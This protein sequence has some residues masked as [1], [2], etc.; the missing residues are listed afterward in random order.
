MLRVVG[1]IAQR[2]YAE[3]V[4]TKGFW[5]GVLL[6]PL[7]FIAIF[8]FSSL[9]ASATPTRHFILI[10]Q[11]GNYQPGITAAIQREHQRRVLQEFAAY[12]QR[13][14]LDIN[15]EDAPA[16]LNPNEQI[17]RLLDNISNDELA[18]LDQWL[19]NGGL[20]VALAMASPSLDPDAPAFTP[21]R[22][23]FIA[24]AL[25]SG[26][27]DRASPD[28]IVSQ[29]RPWLDGQQTLNEGEEQIK[30]FALILIPANADTDIQSPDDTTAATAAID[31]S[32]GIQYWSS[33]LTDTRLST[34]IQN[35]INSTVRS[36]AYTDQ[37]IDVEAVRQIQRTRLPLTR[38]DPLK[39]EGNESVSLADTFRQ[40]APV[41]FVYLMFITLMQSV[42]YLLSNTIEEKSNRIIEVLLAS[43]T[44]GE[45]MMGKL[46]GIGMSGITTIV[47]WLV[48][49]LLF[50][51]FYQS[52]ETAVISQLL[53]VLLGS[54]LIPYFLFYYIAG[55][56]LYAGFFLAI[57]SLCNTLKEA[58][59]LMLPMMMIL[60]LPLLTMSF[61]AQDPN[62]SIA[63]IMS[64]I[65]LFTPF[66]MMNRAAAQPPLFDIIGTTLVLLLSIVAM[67]WLSGRVFRQGVLRSGQPPR[68]LEI[69]RM[70]TGKAD[71]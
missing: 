56:A 52:T 3:N 46:L 7:I 27:D 20:N 55:Y 49:F 17:D 66:I 30:L 34:I 15:F 16:D 11:T 31:S 68:L 61:I 2:E 33:N 69:Y 13:H 53:D 59:N 58:Q 18:A 4:R 63:R 48:S 8:L 1:L 26:V 71:A 12:V 35:S 45:L 38:L 19:A 44:P 43:V 39:S 60:L 32:N 25:P 70:L 22:P 28:L 50:I 64:W 67:L 29:L 21:P 37:G 54:E 36:R 5:I 40:W 9:L 10:D 62:G 47:A 51:Q 14:R 42:Q 57:G 41:G 65:P 23:Q 24:A 6:L